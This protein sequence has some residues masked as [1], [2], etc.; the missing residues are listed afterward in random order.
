MTSPFNSNDP[1]AKL[2]SIQNQLAEMERRRQEQQT[3]ESVSSVMSGAGQR[4]PT[5]INPQTLRP[6]MTSTPQRQEPEG[7]R[8]G[9]FDRLS[10]WAEAAGGTILGNWARVLPGEQ[11]TFERNLREAEEDIKT[12]F[13]EPTN[14]WQFVRQQGMINAEA[15]RRTDMPSVQVD[16]TGPF[17]ALNLPG[18]ATLEKVDLGVKG[19]IE[20]AADPLNYI[21]YVG[22]A[23][24]ATKG[25]ATAI[26][27]AGGQAILETTAYPAKRAFGEVVE[28]A[29]G[30]MQPRVDIPTPEGAKAKIAK[31][32]ATEEKSQGAI[33]GGVTLTE[34]E[35]DSVRAVFPNY[36]PLTSRP[37]ELLENIT[38]SLD[39]TD[40]AEVVPIGGRTTV[41]DPAGNPVE[42][43]VSAKSKMGTVEVTLDDGTTKIL[44]VDEL[45]VASPY[46]S[47][48]KVGTFSRWES[49]SVS[50]LTDAELKE[51]SARL[52]E[53]AQQV[54]DVG[55]TSSGGMSKLR[56]N[57]ALKIETRR[58]AGETVT[59]PATGTTAAA[60]T[61]EAV[62]KEHRA[63]LN[64]IK[65]KIEKLPTKEV[66]EY[67]IRPDAQETI[68]QS[69]EYAS[70]QIPSFMRRLQD[71]AG[72]G[73]KI[74][75]PLRWGFAKMN[76][77]IFLP[78]VTSD[79]VGRKVQ[80]AI[81][82]HQ[83]RHAADR[84]KVVHSLTS[85]SN[86]RGWGE[87]ADKDALFSTQGGFLKRGGLKGV[88]DVDEKGNL[89]NLVEA[90]PDP[91]TGNSVLATVSGTD[92]PTK[93]NQY[94]VAENAFDDRYG[95][96][97]F[98][99]KFGDNKLIT[100]LSDVEIS[101][102]ILNG[103]VH[104]DFV[105]QAFALKHIADF[106]EDAKNM[107]I[108]RGVPVTDIYGDEPFLRYVFRQAI[109]KEGQELPR[110]GQ[111]AG[112]VQTF[113][114]VR[115]YK[116]QNIVD[117]IDKKNVEYEPDM[118]VAAAD[119]MDGVYE[120]IRDT[121]LKNSL[122]STAVKLGDEHLESALKLVD[123]EKSALK[124]LERAHKLIKQA[125]RQ[126]TKLKGRDIA[127]LNRIGAEQN[128]DIANLNAEDIIK[129]AKTDKIAQRDKAQEIAKEARQVKAI[130]NN[131]THSDLGDLLVK[132]GVGGGEVGEEFAARYPELTKL[133][134]ELRRQDIHI[135]QT[136]PKQS[137]RLVR[138]PGRKGMKPEEMVMADDSATLLLERQGASFETI[139]AGFA[140]HFANWHRGSGKGAVKEVGDKGLPKTTINV[141]SPYLPNVEY[142]I[143]PAKPISRT[144]RDKKPQ[145]GFRRKGGYANVLA[146]EGTR[147]VQD[148][149]AW[150]IY[151]TDKSVAAARRGA[152]AE[153]ALKQAK[154]SATQRRVTVEA[155]AEDEIASV[156]AAD[157]VSHFP[158]NVS[159]AAARGY[160]AT[161][162][163][164]TGQSERVTRKRLRQ[165]HGWGGE[166][167]AQALKK[168]KTLRKK[169]ADAIEKDVAQA[170][171]DAKRLKVEVEKFGL[172]GGWSR[173]QRQWFKN[174]YPAYI[175]ELE[176][177]L[178][179]DPSK[180]R[181]ERL[182]E[183]SK[184]FTELVTEQ[185]A[186]LD[187]AVNQ[188][189]DRKGDIAG[190]VTVSKKSFDRRFA[191]IAAGKMDETVGKHKLVVL[192]GQ[193]WR[194]AVQQDG[195]TLIVKETSRKNLP[196][197]TGMYFREA[198]VKTIE[199]SLL[200]PETDT[201]L[202]ILKAFFLR[203]AP[204]AGDIARVLKAGFDFGAPFL[205]GIPLLARRPD[206]WAK[207]TAR[208]YK[209]A[210]NSRAFHQV[211]LQNNIDVIREMAE[212]N[213]P[214]GAGASDY[215][216]ALQRGGAVDRLGGFL[217]ENL[218]LKHLE[219]GNLKLA[220]KAVRA[221]GR[222]IQRAG[223]VFEESFEGFH[224]YAR[225]E[226][227][228]A[229]RDNA[230]L[231]DPERG[232]L[233]LAAF[234]RN[235]TG[236]LDTGMLGV[237]PS[238]QAF[239][240]GW[241]FFSPRYTRASLALMADAF[242][243][244]VRGEQARQT[245]LQM[246][247]AGA[248]TYMA[249]A[250][251]MG[252]DIKLDPR[253]KSAGGDGAEFMTISIAG[254]NVGIGSF[255]TS[256]I[257]MLASTTTTAIND[258]EILMQPSTRD[259][260]I[261]RWIR[262]RSAPT[263]GF[264]AY[265]FNQ[266]TFLG[267]SLESP[268]DWAAHITK[269]TLPFTLENAI[270]EDGPIFG[271]LAA[272]V[273]AEFAG[274]RTFPVSVI[275]YRNAER[276]RSARARFDKGWDELN[277]L[278]KDSLENDPD[279]D[280]G[281]LTR[282]VKE[283]ATKMQPADP[284]SADAAIDSYFSAKGEIETDWRMSIKS[285]VSL[286]E[287]QVIDTV[288]FKEHYLE[289]ANA[290][291]R[292][293]VGE[294]SSDPEFRLVKEYFEQLAERNGPLLPEDEAF[295]EYIETVVTA[296][297]SH[298][299]I[300]FDFRARDIEENNFTDRYG[301]EMLAYVKERFKS[302]R[303]SY[304]FQ[305]PALIDELYIGR[306]NYEYYWE[307]LEKDVLSRQSDPERIRELHEQYYRMSEV[308]R[309]RYKEAN[310]ELKTFLNTLEKA[311]RYLREA[312][313]SL[314][315]FLYRWGFTSTL[316]HKDNQFEGADIYYRQHQATTFGVDGKFPV[317][318]VLNSF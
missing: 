168:A 302:A 254:Q 89:I 78:S 68:E 115:R 262:S 148:V 290:E 147:T 304:D 59:N 132:L 85:L 251:A 49:K 97:D 154:I 139:K 309:K 219:K 267:E 38:K 185:K 20:L 144:V 33:V 102:L 13:G 191:H 177:S 258:P 19:A 307:D 238:Q 150:H 24:L 197:L 16:I 261:A 285:A 313:A 81:F 201:E 287:R 51:A 34:K 243:G 271:R 6:Q 43:T 296:D 186:V 299:V 94:A 107:L 300:G 25:S 170:S 21:P 207:A 273:P 142:Q 188:L 127:L 92:S 46:S 204:A 269:Q 145:T 65:K 71:G 14:P 41:F 247:S 9:F 295:K 277:G 292:A 294:A 135:K 29:K 22:V 23:K 224:D 175:K 53:A 86:F 187:N 166:R 153:P 274:G 234:I 266:A 169:L 196:F 74:V 231:K 76:P 110:S 281:R 84:N 167:D 160:R 198:D 15:F 95:L 104:K 35:L 200:L 275:E 149:P 246:A 106:A 27:A 8:K 93:F 162:P 61:V 66:R 161:N 265:I 297:F 222:G 225:I 99:K 178:L 36:D 1:F 260:P 298:P 165:T 257:R 44:G 141:S 67:H 83:I 91:K 105:D 190:A 211:Y 4:P 237:S 212:L 10:S 278:Q 72:V 159:E 306:S 31:R 181:T 317:E 203:T 250:T 227:F 209:I 75:A 111:A 136:T 96:G 17:G 217:D 208:H 156:L 223:K 264:T 283:E 52:G 30:I 63:T 157:V 48:Y 194:E 253:P 218:K 128:I 117:S 184:K 202:G 11:G 80:V 249:Y 163:A 174:H 311:R 112:S 133:L 245:F 282:I 88:L 316:A 3:R 288:V 279:L 220:A 116:G 256:M 228:K 205:Q 109:T 182:N 113:E 130:V 108:E 120:V 301:Q 126:K 138:V 129:K 232:L 213:I 123:A 214:I 180:A 280:L 82:G 229:M 137:T 2:R 289:P 233:D 18:D 37:E 58:R 73:R 236:A 199:K 164:F 64:R 315:A 305:F 12:K 62:P 270:F 242:Q 118:M 77:L 291:R 143:K 318:Q 134:N 226:M 206:I 119:F 124:E 56:D 312:D 310:P 42:V 276:E 151:Y 252:Q 32:K 155:V 50:E 176:A 146:S 171:D 189:E 5:Q 57:N 70:N 210:A 54:L 216:N 100:E 179:L 55:D 272:G 235:S 303:E 7:G 45:D 255:W 152:D 244:G 103:T 239:E 268:S 308:N 193:T 248:L 121:D 286:F 40:P 39:P 140:R 101:E 284:G 28:S 131:L 125:A 221:P 259:N 114:K 158:Y 240:R 172:K 47:D 69:V 87:V 293:K 60:R 192:T 79:P 183:L 241:L 90:A 215:F 26:K 122:M 263:T 98:S 173:G 195:K 230:A 314:D